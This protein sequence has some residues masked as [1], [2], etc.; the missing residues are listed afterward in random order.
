MAGL[1]LLR[2]PVRK[3][4][5]FPVYLLMGN[6]MPQE[7]LW[8]GTL[9]FL[10]GL[11]FSSM[12]TKP[13]RFFLLACSIELLYNSLSIHVGQSMPFLKHGNVPDVQ[14]GLLVCDLPSVCCPIPCFDSLHP[15]QHCQLQ[16]TSRPTHYHVLLDENRFTADEIQ[17]LTYRLCFLQCRATK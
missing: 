3:G 9:L 17:T 7:L 12:H 16:G 2:C 14:S 4:A 8:T 11:I 1:K 13:Y 6:V 15:S 5:Y 10:T